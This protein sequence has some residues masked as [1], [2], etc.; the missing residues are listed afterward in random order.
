M[1]IKSIDDLKRIAHE[2]NDKI[3]NE[4]A[5]D[6]LLKVLTDNGMDED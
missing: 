1:N 3:S 6:K 5:F 2:L 4:S